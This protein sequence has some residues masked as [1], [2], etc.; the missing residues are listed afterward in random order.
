MAKAKIEVI[1]P[2]E[3][4]ETEPQTEMVWLQAVEEKVHAAAGRIRDLREENATLRRR[5]EE[6]EERLAAPAVSGTADRWVEERE[7]IRGKVERLVEH[8]E[9]ML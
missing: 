3:T 9:G 5:I 8:L 7:E 6:L 1:I 4:T 2:T